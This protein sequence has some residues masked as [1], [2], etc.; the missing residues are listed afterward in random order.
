[1]A[2]THDFERAFGFVLHEAARLLSKRFDQKAR[3]IGLTRAQCSV[4]FR[5]SMQ[6]G[7]N[8][9]RLAELMEMEPISLARLLDR[10]EQA[11]WVERRADPADRRAHRLYMTA[12]AKPVL[13][14]M[15]VVGLE[16]RGEAL[17]GISQADRDRMIDLLIHVRRNLSERGAAEP[18]ADDVG[19]R[20]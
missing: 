14:R 10:M 17:A 19:A 7:M 20:A 8:Q 2:Q 5:L 15:L 3:A 4:L 13:E 6:E 11:G 9:A 16:T 18:Q 1:M 12:K